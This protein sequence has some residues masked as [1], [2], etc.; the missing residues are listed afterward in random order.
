MLSA[1]WRSR[2]VTAWKPKI[3]LLF[4]LFLSFLPAAVRFVVSALAGPA[5]SGRR[6][7]DSRRSGF[8]ATQCARLALPGDQFLAQLFR[9]SGSRLPLAAL[10]ALGA[11]LAL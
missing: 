9:G 5:C 8:A 11:L 6:H 7:R 2:A 4:I 3:S 1:S 10:A